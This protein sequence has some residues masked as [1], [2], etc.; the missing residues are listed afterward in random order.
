MVIFV[1]SLAE[2]DQVLSED[3]TVNRLHESLSLFETLINGP[4]FAEPQPPLFIPPPC[5]MLLLNKRDVFVEK[6]ARTPL[7][8]CFPLYQPPVPPAATSTSTSTTGAKNTAPAFPS[9]TSTSARP[10]SSS[11]SSS[12]PW[13]LPSPPTSAAVAS[14]AEYESA[15]SYIVAQF[16]ER[17]HRA[18]LR[19]PNILRKVIHLLLFAVGRI[20]IR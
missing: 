9:S 4:L 12:D 20:L 7:S 19:R 1:V 10:S 6:L 16:D 18:S 17:F 11:S 2:Y 15:L 5:I 14:P 13:A 8:V 3:P